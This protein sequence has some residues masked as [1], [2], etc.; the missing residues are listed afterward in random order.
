ML[1][2]VCRQLGVFKWPYKET[3]LIARRQGRVI[4]ASAPIPHDLRNINAAV[5]SASTTSLSTAFLDSSSTSSSSSSSSGKRKSRSTA[6]ESVSGGIAIGNPVRGT[7][8]GAKRQRVASV[9][10][11][12]K[13]PRATKSTR[14]ACPGRTRPWSSRSYQHAAQTQSKCLEREDQLQL[15]DGGELAQSVGW[16]PEDQEDEEEKALDD[17]QSTQ[18]HHVCAH[19]PNMQQIESHEEDEHEGKDVDEDV[20]NFEDDGGIACLWQY[21][22]KENQAQIDGRR[23]IRPDTPPG[24]H[25]ANGSDNG[26]DPEC[27]HFDSEHSAMGRRQP[28]DANLSEMYGCDSRYISTY[29]RSMADCFVR[30]VMP[31]ICDIPSPAALSVC[32]V[33]L[34]SF[35]CK[36]IR[37][38][39]E[40]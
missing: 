18:D 29:E 15:E 6:F 34:F 22:L 35:L 25:E 40:V 28:M 17:S 1:K 32:Q 8:T 26:Y 13:S 37:K 31:H 33:S 39:K 4:A 2:K 19:D 14:S 27:G 23:V 20:R 10:A 12:P 36:M 3:K 16:D 7:A 5:A 38:L 30:P 21:T 24:L 11:S 9:R